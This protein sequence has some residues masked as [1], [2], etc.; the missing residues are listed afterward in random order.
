[1]KGMC[2]FLSV[3][4]GTASCVWLCVAS[5]GCL[6]LSARSCVTLLCAC[7]VPIVCICRSA[8]PFKS[9]WPACSVSDCNRQGP[10]ASRR[11]CCKRYV[12]M[13]HRGAGVVLLV[14]VV[15]I[16]SR[17]VVCRTFSTKG[18]RVSRLSVE[19]CEWEGGRVSL[20]HSLTLPCVQ[21]TL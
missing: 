10:T 3:W 17:V 12:H 5:C 8:P 6:Y 1:M 16:P 20:C 15:G 11:R 2:L 7:G 19:T 9:S 14:V 21:G 13:Q 4:R 18:A